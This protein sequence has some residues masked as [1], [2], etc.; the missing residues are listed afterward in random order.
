MK[1]AILVIAL[2]SQP[3]LAAKKCD[4]KAAVLQKAEQAAETYVGK[5]DGYTVEINDPDFE[6]PEY[7]K[8][9]RGA[10]KWKV[11][12]R[13]N[14]MCYGSVAVSVKPGT[15]T[16]TGKAKINEGECTDE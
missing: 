7:L 10:E 4:V 12:M 8:T 1:Y 11:D 16:I 2:I 14:D 13:Y 15:C 3:S 5:H 9:V 6:E